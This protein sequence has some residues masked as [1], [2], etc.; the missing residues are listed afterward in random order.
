LIAVKALAFLVAS[1]ALG[2][3]LSRRVFAVGA[4]FRGEGVLLA[5]GLSFCFLLA[6]LASEINLAPIVGAFAAGLIL[7]DVHYRDFVDRGEQGLEH[8][9]RPIASFLTPIFFVLMGM[10]TDLT[11]LLNPS[12][13]VLGAA[14]TVAAIAGKQICGLGIRE[15]NVDRLTVGVGMV[16]RGEVGLIFANIGRSIPLG[17][18]SLLSDAMYSAV[19]MMV[20]ITTMITPPA[21]KW[22]IGRKK[23]SPS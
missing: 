13:L 20:I 12:G 10:T 18:H 2:R 16:P 5:L 21:L 22:S 6:Y 19:V 4:L 11:Q 9:I 3:L 17:G 15:A 7:E 8:L 14:L 23:P 1:L